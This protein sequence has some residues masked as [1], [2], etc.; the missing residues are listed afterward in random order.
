MGLV[1]GAVSCQQNGGQGGHQDGHGDPGPFLAQR[2]LLVE[3]GIG[4]RLALHRLAVFKVDA[5]ALA[6]FSLPLI[7]LHAAVGI[8]IG[9]DGGHNAAVGDHNGVPSVGQK[10][11][12]GRT[13]PVG[14]V[15]AAFTAGTAVAGPV[16][17]LPLLIIL[18]GLQ[19]I[20]ALQLKNAVIH[21]T[22]G[23]LH[24]MFPLAEQGFQRL[25]GALHPRGDQPF[26]LGVGIAAGG[27]QL[28]QGRKALGGKGHVGFAA[29]Q[30]L[31]ICHRP[32]VA[33]EIDSL[34][35]TDLQKG[36]LLSYHI[37]R[38][39]ATCICSIFPVQCG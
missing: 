3:E 39:C 34:H 21:L 24:L 18:P 31:L 1:H 20:V 38:S 10:G 12:E 8:Q 26:A 36:F 13:H 35:G 15:L 9:H 7:A 25:L 2:P 5:P 11:V 17:R 32:S 33:D 19:L 28:S 29:A 30:I 16:A 27:G 37:F 4:H 23:R 14:H 22:E 6:V